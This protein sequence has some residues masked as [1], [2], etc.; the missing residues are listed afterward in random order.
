MAEVSGHA[1]RVLE[2][3]TPAFREAV[4][5]ADCMGT[6]YRGRLGIYEMIPVDDEMRHLIVSGASVE[7]MKALARNQGHRF[8]RDDGLLKAWQGLTTVE[9]V[10]RV[11]G[12]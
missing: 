8:L 10:L 12:H 1:A 4:G 9:E 7:E 3:A 5:C 6:G 2:G 11:V